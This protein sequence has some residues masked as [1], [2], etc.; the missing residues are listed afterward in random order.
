MW[1][2]GTC[3]ILAGWPPF[4]DGRR[5]AGQWVLLH[6]LEQLWSDLMGLHSFLVEDIANFKIIKTGGNG[7][8]G[9]RELESEG[10]TIDGLRGEL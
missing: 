9:E 7:R 2:S 1:L 4:P 5:S 6:K 3:L 8:G 10:K